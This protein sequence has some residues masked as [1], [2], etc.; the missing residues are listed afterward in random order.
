MIKK[1]VRYDK[2]YDTLILYYL[3]LVLRPFIYTTID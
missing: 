2:N 1:S 3:K